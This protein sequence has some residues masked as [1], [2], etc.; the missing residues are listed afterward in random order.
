MRGRNQPSACRSGTACAGERRHEVGDPGAG[1]E[2]EPLRLVGTARR[3]D[4][5]GAG[6]RDLPGKDRLAGADVGARR[7][8]KRRVRHD[9]PLGCHEAAVRLHDG[10]EMLRH[11]PSGKTG[12]ELRRGQHLMGKA[13]LAAGGKRALHDAPVLGAGVD[14]AGH[15][16]EPLARG[17]LELPP[18]LVG[19]PEQRH[20]G[21]VLHI[22][23]AD[24]A[25]D[26]VRGA[27]RMRDVEALEPEHAL[28]AS[29]ELP[30]RRRTHA[31]DP[32]DDHV[33]GSA[34]HNRSTIGPYGPPFPARLSIEG[35][36]R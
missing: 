23:E 20:V 35:E 19:A 28:A 2:H 10:R 27:H 26:A 8:G 31:A 36:S 9:R 24:D 13:V 33:V 4:A 11:A 7:H 12:G 1:R 25:V 21:R 30:A 15:E 5:H 18:H 14:A 17:G 34:R 29:G 6:A 32:G 22:G 16:Q 3:L